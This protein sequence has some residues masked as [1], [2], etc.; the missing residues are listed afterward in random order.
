MVLRKKI[1][2]VCKPLRTLTK[3][4]KGRL[5][6]WELNKGFLY[7]PVEIK[8][9]REYYQLYMH[10]FDNSDKKDQFLEKTQSITTHSV[11]NKFLIDS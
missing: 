2:K 5:P 7:I 1:N 11:W 8:R 9:I 10:K 4:I 6:I 3:K